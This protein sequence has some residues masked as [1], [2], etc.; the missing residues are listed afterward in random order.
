MGNDSTTQPVYVRPEIGEELVLER[1]GTMV[2]LEDEHLSV[3]L[4]G[5]IQSYSFDL[6]RLAHG[7]DLRDDPIHRLAPDRRRIDV[8]AI[9][10][11]GVLAAICEPLFATTWNKGPSRKL[12]RS[13][14]AARPVRTHR[15]ESARC[16]EGTT[17][18][19]RHPS[20][21]RRR[22]EERTGP[23]CRDHR[24]DHVRRSVPS[25]AIRRGMTGPD[26]DP[27]TKGDPAPR[28]DARPPDRE[29]LSS[30]LKRTLTSTSSST[31]GVE[32]VKGVSSVLATGGPCPSCRFRTQAARSP[33]RARPPHW[34]DPG[35]V[36]RWRSS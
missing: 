31:R 23:L 25:M 12:P 6:E 27:P 5:H 34:P 35:L 21:R 26:D 4:E 28:R 10:S 17:L 13:G 24:I 9:G 1:R 32:A 19:T 20:A 14:F 36:D 18:D 30:D 22:G 3:V 33:A 8:V 16:A 7:S 29:R 2:S 11:V 15:S